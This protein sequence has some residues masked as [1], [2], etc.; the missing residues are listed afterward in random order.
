MQ[1]TLQTILLTRDPGLE[2]ELTSLGAEL[3][4]PF[5]LAIRVEEDARRAV[6]RAIERRVD[7]ILVELQQGGEALV[8]LA[9]DLRDAEHAPAVAAIYRP[10]EF[11]GDASLSS[12]FVGL[13]RAGVRDFLSR[14][15][16]TT[17][18][19]SLV[20]RELPEHAPSRQAVGRVV[21][22]V[23]SKG[24][25]G[26][27]TTAVEAVLQLVR[28]RGAPP[29][30]RVLVAAPTHTAADLLCASLARVAASS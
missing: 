18:L 4:G 23:G 2:S 24:G 8:Q 11:G 5:R 14:P 16:S 13:L 6:V 26:K 20:E 1:R 29:S 17:D 27:S 12:R 7:L 28:G 22:F 9:E 25:V 10:Q 15:L 19:R 30:M 21:S 3:G